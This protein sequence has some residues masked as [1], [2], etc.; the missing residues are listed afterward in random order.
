MEALQTNA[1]VKVACYTTVSMHEALSKGANVFLHV[2]ADRLK[3]FGRDQGSEQL[4]LDETAPGER[5]ME[6]FLKVRTSRGWKDK[7]HLILASEM[8]ALAFKN[9]G[10]E[11]KN[12]HMMVVKEGAV[13]RIAGMLDQLR[14]RADI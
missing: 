5:F 1:S 4:V 6:A 11:A 7:F 10:I 3:T 14:E 13:G 2:I 8:V 9:G 12:L